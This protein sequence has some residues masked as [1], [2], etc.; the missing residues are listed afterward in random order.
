MPGTLWHSSRNCFRSSHHQTTP[1]QACIDWPAHTVLV[2]PCSTI[3]Y[4][5]SRVS[6]TI[7]HRHQHNNNHMCSLTEFYESF[8]SAATF[9]FQL[10]WLLYFFENM[11]GKLKKKYHPNAFQLLQVFTKRKYYNIKWCFIY[12]VGCTRIAIT[13]S[14]C[15]PD[16]HILLLYYYMTLL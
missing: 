4:Y 10:P 5:T 2:R 7:Y 12:T 8:Y 11:K 13:V 16:I 3:Q 14:L 9:L 1:L 6:A 15:N